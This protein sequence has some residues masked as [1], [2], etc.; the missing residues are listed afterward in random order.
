MS[1]PID[2]SKS[3]LLTFDVCALDVG[4]E[5]PLFA[6][7]ECNYG[8]YENSKHKKDIQIKKTLSYYELDLG[9]NHVVKK[10]TETLDQDS[11]FMLSLPGGIDGP[12]G[13]L[14]CSENL[15]QYKYLSKMTHCLPIPKR[16]DNKDAPTFI[17][18]GI[19]HKM[20]RTFFVLLQSNFGDLYKIS[21][22]FDP[23][24]S[25]ET[26][27]EGGAVNSIEISYF[28]S[29]PVCNSLVI[30]KSGFLYG[31]CENGDHYIYQFEKLGDDPDQITW[32]SGEYPDDVAAIEEKA[33]FNVKPFDNIAFIEI[34]ENLNPVI[35]SNL[36]NPGTVEELPTINAIC[37]SGSRSSF[38]SLKSEQH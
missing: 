32:K 14:L 26:N 27:G 3:K 12:S 31:A 11:N 8:D 6:A 35:A 4:F 23:Q 15:I 5:N 20:K 17:V 13:F 10:Y 28:D 1:S 34:S 7:I 18:S 30:F 21:F 9:L 36:Y 19:V 33:I 22:D 24:D 25:D 29:M 38:K 16:E 37:G 2:A